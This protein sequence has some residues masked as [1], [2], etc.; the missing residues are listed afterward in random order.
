MRKAINR[1]GILIATL[2]L[3]TSVIM[4]EEKIYRWVDADG[5]VHFGE[6][7]NDQFD[8]KEVKVKKDPE[9]VLPPP[10]QTPATTEATTGS[11]SEADEE[12]SYAQQRR[13]QRAK[14]RKE[15]AEK[16][17]EV[18]ESCDLHQKLV[19]QLEPMT[20]VIVQ[21][22]D[23]TVERMDDDER[24]KQLKK[25]KDFIAENCRR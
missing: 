4:A 13:D 6:M 21:R 18:A 1:T 5:V 19:T 20:R 7:P 17:A 22:E 3:S 9:Y 2:A 11:A 23:G 8:S 12:V 15:A 14:Q 10:V 25:S 24:V 16:K